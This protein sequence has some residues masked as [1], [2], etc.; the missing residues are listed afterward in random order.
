MKRQTGESG[1]DQGSGGARWCEQ[2]CTHVHTG[3]LMCALTQ[4]TH[5]C[6]CA[7]LTHVHT[8][9]LMCALTRMHTCVLVCAHMYSRVYTC[10]H[11][12]TPAHAHSHTCA[13][14]RTHTFPFSQIDTEIQNPLGRFSNC[15]QTGWPAGLPRA[16]RPCSAVQ[17]GLSVG[18]GPSERREVRE[19]SRCHCP[20]QSRGFCL[21]GV[22]SEL[23]AAS[24]RTAA[25]HSLCTNLTI[26]QSISELVSIPR[27]G[28]VKPSVPSQMR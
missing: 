4:C 26:G 9:M 13:H 6:S 20:L 22:S 21:V 2:P 11:V 17:I 1:A 5:T 14:T 27:Q 24:Q 28:S 10:T 19:G 3:V 12:H 8:R 23:T 18:S 15:F 25:A 16:H 7:H